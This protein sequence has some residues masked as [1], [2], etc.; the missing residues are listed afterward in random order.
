M[1]TVARGIVECGLMLLYI[2]K[3]MYSPNNG[4]SDGASYDVLS[5]KN[6]L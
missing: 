6:Q 3:L 1:V 5:F 4:V 2:L